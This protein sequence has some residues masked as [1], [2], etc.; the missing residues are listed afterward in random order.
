MTSTAA[1]SEH[2]LLLLLLLPVMMTL[3]ALVTICI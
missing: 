1:V 3:C 2:L